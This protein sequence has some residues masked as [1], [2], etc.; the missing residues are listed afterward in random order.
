LID[1]CGVRMSSSRRRDF[2]FLCEEFGE[3]FDKKYPKE[4]LKR[5]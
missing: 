2:S 3:E 5:K 4:I 1:I